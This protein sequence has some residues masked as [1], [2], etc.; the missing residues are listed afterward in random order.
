MRK[1]KIK[2]AHPGGGGDT[3]KVIRRNFSLRLWWGF[4]R[5]RESFNGG[6][7]TPGVGEIGSGGCEAFGVHLRLEN[8]KGLGSGGNKGPAGY[9]FCKR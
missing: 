1:R 3:A 7:A 6:E 2:K 9:F 4:P 5:L 8:K